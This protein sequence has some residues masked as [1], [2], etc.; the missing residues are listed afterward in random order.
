[1]LIFQINVAYIYKNIKIMCI[2]QL[3][4]VNFHKT[5]IDLLAE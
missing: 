4:I 5:L 2:K 3:C 1:M